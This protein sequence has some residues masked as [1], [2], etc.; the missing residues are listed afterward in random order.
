MIFYGFEYDEHSF[1]LQKTWFIPSLMRWA[2]LNGL[3]RCRKTSTSY[4]VTSSRFRDLGRVIRS[5]AKHGDEHLGP[6]T[7]VVDAYLKAR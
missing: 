1:N 4:G 6:I 5:V 7:S 3:S 2:C